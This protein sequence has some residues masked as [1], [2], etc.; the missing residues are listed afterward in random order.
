MQT[1]SDS[2]LLSASVRTAADT[3]DSA[4]KG[5]LMQNETFGQA[6][7]RLRGSRSVRDVADLANCGKSYVSDLENGK[8]QPTEGIAIA[9]DRALGAGGELIALAQHRPGAG[10]LE[11]VDAL[12]RGL[13]ES[14]AAG[15]MTDAT[16]EEWEYT[17]ARHGRATRYRPEEE[18][19]LELLSDFQDLRLVLTHR[20][21]PSA[22][23]KLL[24]ASA[25]L[26]GVMALTLLRLG[27]D[28]S[29]AWWRTGRA[30]AAAAEDRAVLSWLYAQE[31]YQLYYGG[32]LYGAVE[33][34]RRAQQLAGGLPC[35][36]A[37]LAAPLE[38]RAHAQLGAAEPAVRALEAAE[39]ALSRL[40]EEDRI[41]SAF[42]YS[43]SQLRFHAGNAWTHL[44]QT[45]RARE[46]HGRAL[47]LYPPTDYM[48]LALI[49]L[50]R[51]MCEAL[52]GDP[53]AAA[54]HATQTIVALPQQHRSALI[55]CRARE[56]AA[57]VPQAQGAP[58]VQVLREVL[59][60]P[61]SERDDSEDRRGD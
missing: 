6:L 30:A 13:A 10:V 61:A 31:A 52:D 59:A 26:A 40:P 3:A 56:V 35:V 32:D 42:G 60:L 43:E 50:D 5:C 54:A 45:S 28:R 34:A 20:H 4:D 49:S 16:F 53:A 51:A 24:I 27:D 7:R 38:A 9:L 23:K 8:R 22:H 12:Q 39:T 29:R 41:G 15:P 19:L 44:G 18:L 33:L 21:Q 37:A 36:G 57:K 55:I 25:Q 1:V 46:E 2:V 17:V 47:E 58:E 14:L 11:Q 48:D